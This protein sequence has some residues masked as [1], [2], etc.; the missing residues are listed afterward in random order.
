MYALTIFERDRKYTLLYG[1]APSSLRE[2][3][4]LLIS[5]L[6]VT[7]TACVH[8]LARGPTSRLA[9]HAYISR[10]TRTQILA[11]PDRFIFSLAVPPSISVSRDAY[12]LLLLLLNLLLNLLNPTRDMVLR[13]ASTAVPDVDLQ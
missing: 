7:S 8:S 2:R 11:N 13:T 6:T 4:P 3:T 9:T 12:F 5:A 10:R 1:H